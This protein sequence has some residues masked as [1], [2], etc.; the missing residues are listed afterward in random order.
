MV[1]SSSVEGE[2]K[3]KIKELRAENATLRK[4][5]GIKSK[6]VIKKSESNAEG[7]DPDVDDYKETGIVR[8]V[9]SRGGWLAV[10]LVSLSLTSLVMTGFENT[11][12]KHIELAYF[13]PLM[14]GHGGNAGGQTLG[15]VLSA[16]ARGQIGKNDWFSVLVKECAVG[17][18]TG[19]CVGVATLPL[20]MALKIPTHISVAIM[21]TMPFLTVLAAG[22]AAILPFACHAVG[23]DPSVVAAPAMTTL[24]DVGGILVYFLTAQIVFRYFGIALS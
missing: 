15:T 10:F 22:L 3:E 2:L 4:A 6:E 8:L 17:L 16:M 11:L 5:A 23:F 20:L 19:S 24:V 13:V 12:E 14:I 21:L 1:A 7:S 18:G 9:I